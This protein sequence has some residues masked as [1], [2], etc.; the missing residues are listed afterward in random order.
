MVSTTEWI[1]VTRILYSWTWQG[2]FYNFHYSL[3]NAEKFLSL[4]V[5]MVPEI[6][7]FRLDLEHWFFSNV[8]LNLILCFKLWKNMFLKSRDILKVVL[9]IKCIYHKDW[10]LIFL[11]ILFFSYW[12]MRSQDLHCRSVTLYFSYVD[13][14]SKKCSS[15][16]KNKRKSRFIPNLEK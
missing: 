7:Y 10:N 14:R 16:R 12:H 3:A 15:R 1:I 2:V 8:S 9:I 13:C 11:G 5:V 4:F 6:L